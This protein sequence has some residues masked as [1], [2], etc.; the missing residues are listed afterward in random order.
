ML[1][2]ACALPRRYC[3]PY[4]QPL[5]ATVRHS[6][7]ESADHAL[8]RLAQ[9][10]LQFTPCVTQDKT[11]LVL[12]LEVQA[13]LRL[14]GGATSLINQLAHGWQTLGWIPPDTVTMAWG[15]TPKAAQWQAFY[16]SHQPTPPAFFEGDL[17][18]LPIDIVAEARPHLTLMQRMGLR[19]IQQL[20]ALPRQGAT[21]RFGKG[22][23]LALDQAFGRSPDPRQWMTIPENFQARLELPARAENTVLIEQGALRLFHQLVA[24]LAARQSGI[25]RLDL[26]LI[27]DSPPDSLVPLQFAGLT[28]E[29]T[30]LTRLLSERLARFTLKRPVYEIAIHANDISAM[31]QLS[32]DFFGTQQQH[33]QE[34]DALIERLRARLGPQQVQSVVLIDEHRPEKSIVFATEPPLKTQAATPAIISALGHSHRPSWLLPDPQPL[35]MHGH[36]PSYGGPLRLLAG[37]E[38]IEA[39]WWESHAEQA[40]QRDYFIASSAQEELLWIFRT[41][42]HRWFLHGVFA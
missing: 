6:P 1:W 35:S 34:L 17:P 30:R 39:G 13:S 15:P 32:Q 23:L 8:N 42:D 19:K 14:W 9:W 25:L 41:P 2:I 7:T 37:P 21:R 20:E 3:A 4:C 33:Q 16:A 12:L 24:W 29:L 18:T 26:H 28:R 31:P 36:Q 27:H 11:E 22:L 5:P 38:R 40:A 10:A